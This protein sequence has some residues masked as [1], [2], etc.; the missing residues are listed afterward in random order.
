MQELSTGLVKGARTLAVQ[1]TIFQRST[2][3]N[4]LSQAHGT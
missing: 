3:A 1:V 4:P 2:T